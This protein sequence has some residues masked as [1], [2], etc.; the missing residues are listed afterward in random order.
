MR[1]ALQ[2]RLHGRPAFTAEQMA[3]LEA[4]GFTFP[5]ETRFEFYWEKLGYS[6]DEGANG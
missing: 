4:A 6:L 2:R 5:A 3:Y 1:D